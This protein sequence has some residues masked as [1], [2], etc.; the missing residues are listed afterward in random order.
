MVYWHE[1]CVAVR[2]SR[3]FA[4]PVVLSCTVNICLLRLLPSLASAHVIAFLWLCI[5]VSNADRSDPV[6][7][8]GAPS[9]E[10]ATLG[11]SHHRIWTETNAEF[12]CDGTR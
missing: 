6:R 1:E 3:D 5:F 4:Q 11:A 10:T 7:P 2:A 8:R 9:V 12:K